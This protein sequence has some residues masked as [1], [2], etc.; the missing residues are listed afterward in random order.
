MSPIALEFFGAPHI[1]RDGAPVHVT[2]RKALALLVYLVLTQRPH[3][4]D[5]LAGLL[6]PE[7]GQRR[8]R[9]N[10]RHSIY[11]LNDALGPGLLESVDGQVA[12]PMRPDLR[13]DVLRFRRLCAAPVAHHHTH[14]HLCEA[15]IQSLANAA[16]LY[17]GDFLA[18][19]A[20]PDSPEFDTWQLLQR[21]ALQ[22]ELSS[23]LDGLAHVYAEAGRRQYDLAIAYA[24]RWLA[25]DPL[26]EPA[27]RTLM[28]LYAES[29]ERAAAL[30]QYEECV[31]VL[32]DELAVE[33]EAET[34]DLNAQIRAGLFA[35][36]ESHAVLGDEDA[37]PVVPSPAHNLPAQATT[38]IGRAREMEQIARRLADPDCRLLSIV[39]PGG[40][41]K[42]RLAIQAAAAQAHCF[43]DGVR[44]VDLSPVESPNL[45]ATAIERALDLPELGSADPRRRLCDFLGPKQMLLVLDNLEHLL[46][47]V[48]LLPEL[49][50]A[51]PDLSLLV[52]S[53][54]RLNLREEWLSPLEGLSV[55]PGPSPGMPPP[56]PEI[57]PD[58]S[59]YDASLLFINR[60]RKLRPNFVPDAIDAIEDGDAT[61]IG[62]ICRLLGG[63]PLA[64]EL[65]A[66]WTRTLTLPELQAEIQKS[67]DVLSSTLR[68]APPRLRSMRAAF[69]H[70]WRLLSADERAVMRQFSVFRGGCTREAAEAV[71]GATAADLASLVDQSWLRLREGGRYTIHELARQYC[72]EKLEA[73]DECAGV[74][75]G[76]HT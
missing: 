75:P 5:A 25:L 12:V 17:R 56:V 23:T 37:I 1:V 36:H 66:G 24:R 9:A 49:L 42:T 62:A 21:E 14:P 10:L 73:L 71:A 43:R 48:D 47:G 34:F 59:D 28:R 46:D 29:G 6:W 51:A 45:L 39:G 68:D 8:A 74:D 67:L 72:A 11:T 61:A 58:L 22:R 65:A 54:E 55:P 41:G 53:R 64:I 18:G 26:H 30:R 38:F 57:R 20:L 16:N 70:S 32:A 27:H 35:E 15:C 69:D 44:F 76:R 2:R 52:T 50:H 19:F 7:L 63:M 40:S 4:R 60:M 3:S 31:R 13:V 33:P